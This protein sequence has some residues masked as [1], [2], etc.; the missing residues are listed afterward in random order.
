MEILRGGQ[1]RESHEVAAS[2]KTLT[3]LLLFA[4]A[5]VGGAAIVALIVRSMDRIVSA[6]P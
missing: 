4:L 6:L 3:W 5:V 2:A 1:G